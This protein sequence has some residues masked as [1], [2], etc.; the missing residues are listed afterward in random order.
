MTP[1]FEG[2]PIVVVAAIGEA[3]HFR[4]D[5]VALVRN[6]NAEQSGY[7]TS[8]L[9]FFV[10]F[11]GPT[12]E[13]GE[14]KIMRRNLGIGVWAVAIGE[15]G[16][17]PAGVCSLGQSYSYYEAFEFV[18]NASSVLNRMR[19]A[20][21]SRSRAKRFVTDPV[22]QK[23]L[24]ADSRAVR[25]LEDAPR[26]VARM[27]A[28]SRHPSSFTRQSRVSR[29][30]RIQVVGT[31]QPVPIDLDFTQIYMGVPNRLVGFIG[32]NGTGKS[33]VL[34][35]LAAEFI[36]A[37]RAHG[38]LFVKEVESLDRAKVDISRVV[39]VSYGAFDQSPLLEPHISDGIDPADTA[40]ARFARYFYRGL[41]SPREHSS[42][43]LKSRSA[44]QNEL[45]SALQ[46]IKGEDRRAVLVD[47]VIRISEVSR[48]PPGFVESIIQSPSDAALGRLSSGQL[49]ALNIVASLI[50]YLEPGSLLL[51]DEPEVHLHPPLVSA[52]MGSIIQCLETFDSLGIVATHSSVVIQELPSRNVRVF[53][54]I[55]EQLFVDTPEIETF[56]EA[57][58]TIDRHVFG[59]LDAFPAY[60]TT[61]QRAGEGGRRK[62]LERALTNLGAQA[63]SVAISAEQRDDA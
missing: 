4:Y 63:R 25:A 44:V 58:G 52:L 16:H 9:A 42:Q 30:W 24:L 11:R 29:R 53:R 47:T 41:R 28:N 23:A 62:Q 2:P 15:Y 32:E 20:A 51:I 6:P 37:E 33:A 59:M 39:T 46:D 14:V 49:M 27:A 7:L 57:L 8:H 18:A 36:D 19:D 45:I 40:R 10:E 17:L 26:L 50:A 13:I 34:A 35:G 3:R 12:T 56:G 60:A 48:V 1:T 54:R 61:L 38:G 31:R 21:A 5:V 22:F 55:D 43:T